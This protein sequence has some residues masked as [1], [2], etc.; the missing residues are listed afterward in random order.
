ML[1]RITRP[2]HKLW[3]SPSTTLL[4]R[5]LLHVRPHRMIF[6]LAMMFIVVHAV[7][8]MGRVTLS[9]FL[10]DDVIVPAT[11][12]ETKV[13]PASAGR[14][15]I[16]AIHRSAGGEPV[17][18]PVFPRGGPGQAAVNAAQH[19]SGR[20]SDQPPE[21]EP[22]ASGLFES[23]QAWGEDVQRQAYL[24]IKGRSPQE[25]LINISLLAV[26]FALGLAISS[27]WSSYLQKMLILYVSADI[28]RLVF[29]HMLDLEVSFY[30]RRE[31]GDL[32]SRITNDLTAF[33]VA[34]RILLSDLF[35]QPVTILVAFLTALWINPGLTLLSLTIGPPLYMLVRRFGK[36]IKRRA[37]R[38]QQVSGEF[39]QAVSQTIGGVRVIKAFDA[40]AGELKNFDRING[41]I[42]R[43][44]LKVN[45]LHVLSSATIQL[46]NNLLVPG[47]LF[48]GGTMLLNQR[49][50]LEPGDLVV[51][52]GLLITTYRPAKSMAKA[53]NGFQEALAG[54]DRVYEILDRKPTIVD[55]PDAVP[56]PPLAEGVRFE[57]VCFRYPEQEEDVLRGV[58]FTMGKGEVVAL[59]GPSGAG[60][61]TIL[62][63]LPRF[64]DVTGGRVLIEGVDL[65]QLQRS[66]ML[67]RMALVTQDPYL[68]NATVEE[69]LRYGKR[70]ATREEMDQ[71][72][73]DANF[74]GVLE[75]LPQGY[76]TVLGDRGTKL[77]GGERQRL[78]I[79]RALLRDPDILLLDE[80]TASLDSQSERQVQEALERLMEG[81]TTLV[82]A[83][84]LATIRHAS[85]ILVVDD[86]KLVES[87]S[88]E[89]LIARGG[90]Y[91][92]MYDM[93]FKDESDDGSEEPQ[94]EP[95]GS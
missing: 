71:A 75:K 77:S 83:H 95:D 27:Y 81:R 41:Q 56:L 16:A 38:R 66:S 43:H 49:F 69:N 89:E 76:E 9:K 14:T 46:L 24:M 85:K 37:R 21:P 1:A 31:G 6:A 29:A 48:F 39:V 72:L 18:A 22:T 26:F 50:D 10:V 3:N 78:T 68:F 23:A 87:G 42:V 15:A 62:S 40:E 19:L 35:V 59:V 2:L 92:V 79:A 36:K 5:L 91:K 61:S 47:L 11:A 12:D 54:A 73:R 53:W 58:S 17:L 55:A 60:K 93:Q 52:L 4:R 57:D 13:L 82:I 67:A 25:T 8:S 34:M 44:S 88:H 94:E 30:T 80:A 74:A 64:Y 28:R 90:L 86:G 51:F 65:R 84:R 7:C 45:R 32:L 63:L 70:D 20:R 33:E